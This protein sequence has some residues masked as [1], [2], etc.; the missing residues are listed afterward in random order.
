MRRSTITKSLT[1]MLVMVFAFS[2]VFTGCGQKENTNDPAATK[3]AGDSGGKKL[4]GS[5][6]IVGSTSVQPIAQALAD[7]F[8]DIESGVTIDVQGGGSTSGVKSANDGTSDIGTSSRDLKEEEK[9]WGLT[10][11]VIALDGIAVA[12]N[13]ANAVSDLTKDQVAKIFKGEI[14]NWKEVGG[15][16]KEILV[17][18]REAGSGTRGAF[19]EILKLEKKEGD[20]TISLVKADALIADGSGAVLANIASKDNA[21]GYISLGSVDKTIKTVKID[22]IEATIENIKSKTYA[23][24]RPFLM[25]TKGDMKPEVKAFIDYILGEKGQEVV[26]EH[27][28]IKVK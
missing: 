11:H 22:G 6:T 15:A 26:A 14:K 10:E 2:L 4:E 17:V 20:K 8:G 3:P 16:D 27:K 25:L 19:E 9:G 13:P 12:V 23:I 18:S 21:I 7:A 5:I 24:S 28:Y 1:L